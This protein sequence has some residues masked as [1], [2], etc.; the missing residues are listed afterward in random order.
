MQEELTEVNV[1][2][3][4]PTSNGCAVFLGCEEKT[5]V[6]YVDPA[7]GNA[8]N[9]TINQVK[10]ER[11]LTHDLI[12]LILRGME[13][14]IERVVINDVD[15]GTFYARIILKME[16]EFG[17]KTVELDA[18]PSDS[19]VLALQMQKPIHVA[20]RVLDNVE[21]MTEILDRILKKQ[22]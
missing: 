19:M 3:V 10:K 22:E 11:P 17:K 18:R 5:F 16:N 13:T 2:G 8:I 4:M 14:S 9:M 7:I 20:R 15:E 21:D 12:G 1:K 6:I